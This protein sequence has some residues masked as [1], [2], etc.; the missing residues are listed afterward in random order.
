MMPIVFCQAGEEIVVKK[1][2]GL[3]ETRRHLEELGFVP[4]SR[5]LIVAHVNE[6]LIVKVRDT[7]VAIGKDWLKK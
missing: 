6:N 1:I 5:A 4:G 7:R 2:G 3:P